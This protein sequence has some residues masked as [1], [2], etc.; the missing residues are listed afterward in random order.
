MQSP[1]QKLHPCY[2]ALQV[3]KNLTKKKWWCLDICNKAA[4]SRP[5]WEEAHSL[6]TSWKLLLGLLARTSLPGCTHNGSDSSQK[7]S[8]PFLQICSQG[9][10]TLQ[11]ARIPLSLGESHI[12][13]LQKRILS[14]LA[15]SV[16][17]RWRRYFFAGLNSRVM[18]SF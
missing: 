13:A 10:Q 3:E 17:Y 18:V 11:A 2:Q 9:G 8:P 4:A 14:C 1:V 12:W 16:L 15:T 6:G 5:T 7:R